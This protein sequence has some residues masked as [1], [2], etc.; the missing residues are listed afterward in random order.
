MKGIMDKLATHG[1]I[2]IRRYDGKN[3]SPL[4]PFGKFIEKRVIKNDTMEVGLLKTANILM[5]LDVT[6]EIFNYGMLGDDDTL[7]HDRSLTDLV[8]PVGSRFALTHTVGVNYPFEMHLGATIVGGTYSGGITVKE[9]GVFFQPDVIGVIWSR[10]VLDNPIVF[11]E[12]DV[13]DF[14]YDTWIT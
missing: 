14:D 9:I 5:G 8:S 7:N 4:F 6:G 12:L 3:I 13:I 1:V 2:T 11:A 10:V